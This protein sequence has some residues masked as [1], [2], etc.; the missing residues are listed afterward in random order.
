MYCSHY[1]RYFLINL[2]HFFKFVFLCL[3]EDSSY[4]RNVGTIHVDQKITYIASFVMSSLNF[5]AW[6]M[7][8]KVYATPARHPSSLP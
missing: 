6:I 3:E 5:V 7:E 1:I 2:Y 8:H 4:G